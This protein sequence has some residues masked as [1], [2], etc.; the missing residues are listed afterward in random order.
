MNGQE[1]LR[2]IDRLLE[3]HQRGT[4]KTIQ[5][6]I[7]LQVW[8]RGSYQAIGSELG[9]EPEYIKNVAAQLWRLLSE[10][11]GTRV[12]K[13]NLRSILESY[14]RCLTITDWGEAIDVSLFYG[15]QAELETLEDWITDRRCRLVGI[16]GWGGIGKTA[17]AVKL[18]RRF[19]S[20]FEYV[21]WR[22]LRHAPMLNDLLAELLSIFTAS[23]EQLALS[24]VERSRTDSSLG[25][26]MK[27][28]RAQRCLLVLDNVE[29][30][31]QQA[32]ARCSYLS[33]YEDYGEMFD[34]ISDERHQSC[35][36]LTGREKPQG[37]IQREGVNLPVR[38]IQLTGLSSAAAQ[39]ILIDRGLESPQFDR[40]ELISYVGGNP[41]VL[42]LVATTVQN[43]FSGNIMAFLAAGTGVFSNLQD[44]LAQQLDRL[45]PLQQ[46]IMYWLAINREGMTIAR[47]KAE[48]LPAIT[49]PA[50]LE[51]LETLK[52][53]S[54]IETT[55]RGLTQQPA[56]M[57]YVTDM[58]IQEIDREI[59]AG[60]LELL[61]THALLEP[62]SQD[63]IREAQIQLI[64]QPLVDRLLTHFTTRSSLEQQLSS[65]Y[66]N[67]LHQPR[68]ITGYA[69]ENLLDIF[70]LLQTDWPGVPA[71]NT[72]IYSV[73]ATRSQLSAM[74][75]FN[76]FA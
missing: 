26:L 17:L 29:S 54:A 27:Q 65:V 50:L 5:A 59:I 12:C 15:R 19:E 21:V 28:L 57:E 20:R 72:L 73:D 43:L 2:I 74:E 30:I 22:S 63:Y 35:I 6:A 56:I 75:S 34:R 38:S 40:E 36:I 53:R 44:L 61:R 76:S 3:Q 51:A 42:K 39:H 13:G 46:Q 4:L 31:V 58:L 47:L 7:V 14:Q 52:D 32:E 11:V 37:I 23:S 67:L 1:A 18:A 68:E 60:E 49:V 16:F 41:L 25:L 33:G 71:H 64:L 9:Y 55:D 70:D 69:W 66:D 62:Q 45:S 8:N 24:G 48:F 10:L